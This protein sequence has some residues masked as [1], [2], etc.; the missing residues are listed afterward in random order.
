[1]KKILSFLFFLRF[2]ECYSA[3]GN[4]SDG[5]ILAL[6]V[7]VFISLILGTGY[8]IDGLKHI[9]KTGVTKRWFHRNKSDEKYSNSSIHESVAL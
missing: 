6:S 3:T 4:A 8:F 9:V 2:N 7:L 5:E 1:M